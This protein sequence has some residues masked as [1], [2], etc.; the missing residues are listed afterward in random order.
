[1][2]VRLASPRRGEIAQGQHPRDD[3]PTTPH[4]RLH[5]ARGI[6]I[7]AR[8]MQYP[9]G[10]NKGTLPDSFAL[11]E[12]E[13]RPWNINPCALVS[14]ERLLDGEVDSLAVARKGMRHVVAPFAVNFVDGKAIVD[15][16]VGVKYQVLVDGSRVVDVTSRGTDSIQLP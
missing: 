14:L 10:H 9:D 6:L 3:W 7:A 2:L 4:A 15:A 1:V 12:Q 13:R 16:P 5:V 11:D 8:Q